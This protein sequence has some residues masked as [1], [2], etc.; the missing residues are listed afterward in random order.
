MF[1]LEEQGII[2]EM[3]F[4]GANLVRKE[5]VVRGVYLGL[6]DFYALTKRLTKAAHPKSQAILDGYATEE[7]TRKI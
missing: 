1:E 5:L 6:V 7:G 4:Q 2:M 3:P